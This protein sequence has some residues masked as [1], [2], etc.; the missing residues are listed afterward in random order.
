MADI[1][2]ADSLGVAQVNF[3]FKDIS[4][5]QGLYYAVPVQNVDSSGNAIPAGSATDPSYNIVYGP[6]AAGAAPTKSPILASGWDGTNVQILR[7]N[8]LGNLQITG[9][10]AN[11]AAATGNPV[12]IAGKVLTT[13]TAVSD[14]NVADAITD[15]FGGLWVSLKGGNIATPV[16]STVNNVDGVTPSGSSRN[17]SIVNYP[18]K[19]NGTSFDRD[20]KPN[21]VARVASSAASGNPAFLKNG[22]GDLTT[23][24]GVC[25]AT[26]A[27]LQIYNKASAPTIGTDTPVFTYPIPALANFSQSIPNGGYYLS[28]GIAYAFTT[29]AA[30]T[31]GSAAAAVTSFALFGA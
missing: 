13:P 27:Y 29:D 9:N 28:T 16:N 5:G 18:A 11:A 24:W 6:D 26:A 14:G 25:G 3:K 4:A 21:L 20:R 31:T 30:A 15:S 17:L 22:A 23:F 10:V 12:R 19:Y 7:T 2:K 1:I 8:T